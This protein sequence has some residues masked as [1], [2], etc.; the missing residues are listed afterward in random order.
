MPESIE[1][2]SEE[3][4]SSCASE[5]EGPVLQVLS[6]LHDLSKDLLTRNLSMP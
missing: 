6:V 1:I 3:T 2:M 5:P 4:E